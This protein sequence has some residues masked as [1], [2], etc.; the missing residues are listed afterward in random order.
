MLCTSAIPL[1][2]TAILVANGTCE[3]Y[4]SSRAVKT[5]MLEVH[6][7]DVPLV[8]MGAVGTSWLYSVMF[9]MGFA[10]LRSSP[11]LPDF[12]DRRS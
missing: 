12:H 2:P 5:H 10:R 1:P 6:R 3:V 7:N 9:L 4:V 8:C 11:G